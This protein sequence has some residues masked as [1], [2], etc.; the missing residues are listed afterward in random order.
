VNKGRVKP[1]YR[2][3]ENDRVR[4]PPVRRGV[5]VAQGVPTMVQEQL[6]SAVLLEDD[7][8]I[9]LNKPAGL[10]VHGGSSLAYGLI[11]ILRQSRP[12]APTLELVHRLDRET[13]GCLLV[14]KS[15]SM[16]NAL[17]ALLRA[18]GMD[19][20]YIAL[21]A[22]AWEGGAR[23]IAASVMRETGKVVVRAGGKSAYSTMTPLIRYPDS[24]LVEVQIHTGRMH[25][26]RVHAAHLGHPIAGDQKYGNHDF[27]RQLRTHGLQRLFLHAARLEFSAFGR[28]YAVEAPM[29]PRLQCV[30]TNLAEWCD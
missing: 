19:K 27:N 1:S 16:L 2:L 15:R 14:A 12:Y 13:S 17:H 24:T 18:G 21:V 3:A 10:A 20:R 7:D 8:L 6:T 22:G 29:D 11:E 30:L 9:I 4:I 28:R 23:K 25:Q 26:I 5:P